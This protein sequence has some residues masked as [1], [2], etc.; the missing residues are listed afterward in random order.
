MDK[1]NI[2]IVQTNIDGCDAAH[3]RALLEPR[4]EA[5]SPTDVIILPE[6]FATGFSA[7]PH[8]CAEPRDGE[9][10]RWMQRMAEQKNCVVC[11]SILTH[12]NNQFFNTFVWMQPDGNFKTY[13][14]K[15]V[16][17]MGA[18][19]LSAGNERV[20]ID[21]KGWKIRPFIC[22]DLRFPLWSRNRFADGNYEYDIAL[23]IANW[24]RSR[25]EVWKALIPARSIENM[26]YSIGVNRTGFDQNEVEY[27][28]G[29]MV[30]NPMGKAETMAQT[31]ENEIVSCTLSKQ[32]LNDFRQKFMVAADWDKF[33]FL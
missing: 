25:S 16:F 20:V 6:T 22:Y 32:W 12:D 5:L 3:N 10:F 30:C 29:S 17:T 8:S 26:V 18:E 33:R 4:L 9:T 14:K 31:T 15:H 21:Y 1:L 27:I 11:G 24:P 28:G 2:T 7:D 19:F 23:Y 13:N